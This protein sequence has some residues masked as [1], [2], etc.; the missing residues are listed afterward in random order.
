MCAMSNGPTA[1]AKLQAV[2]SKNLFP[3]SRAPEEALSGLYLYFSCLDQSHEISQSIHSPEGAYWHGVMHRQEPDPGNAG[4]WFRQVGA[5]PV[6]PE[7]SN[8]AQ[9]IG[10][11]EAPFAGASLPHHREADLCHWGTQSFSKVVR[12]PTKIIP[13]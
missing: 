9:T 12:C 3:N 8:A 1:L 4:Y 6:F 10:A 2:T 13:G 5:H 7:L 11:M